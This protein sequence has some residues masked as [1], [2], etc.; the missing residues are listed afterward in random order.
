M[1]H[2]VQ[3]G[4]G[5]GHG[6]SQLARGYRHLGSDIGCDPNFN[7]DIH[8]HSSP[9]LDFDTHAET[10]FGSHYQANSIGLQ[11]WIP[12]FLDGRIQFRTKGRPIHSLR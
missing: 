8:H 2:L 5:V 11:C 6:H 7:L 3:W 9:N 1:S 12:G 4:R 10:D